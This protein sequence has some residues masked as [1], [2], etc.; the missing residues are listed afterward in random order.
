MLPVMLTMFQ[1][2]E[3]ETWMYL[4]PI[5]GQQQLMTAVLRGDPMSP[6]GVTLATVTTLALAALL[7]ALLTRLLRTER[8][9]F[10][11]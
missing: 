4:V 9:V 1:D 10:G 3:T 5:A 6:T 7:F 11:S 2:I 8:V